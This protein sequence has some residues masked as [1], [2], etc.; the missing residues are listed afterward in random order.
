[1]EDTSGEWSKLNK[2]ITKIDLQCD[3]IKSINFKIE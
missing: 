1:M 2:S 3:L